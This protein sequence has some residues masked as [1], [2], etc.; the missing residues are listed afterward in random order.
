LAVV[1]G[2][3]V[4]ILPD[5]EAC[6]D[7]AARLIAG[8][9]REAAH[10]R[11]VAHWATTGGSTPAP[12]YRELARP[13]L[14]DEVPWEAVELWWGDDRY[15]P[16]DHPL[17]NVN[18]AT[19]GLIEMAATSGQSG[20]GQSGTDVLAG[21]TAGAPIPPGNVHPIPMTAAIAEGGGPELAADRYAA[22]LIAAGPEFEDGVPKFDLL[23]AGV[24]PDGHVLSVF[25]G[26]P[27]F[28]RPEPV[29]GVP[30][31]S[32]VEPHVARVTLNPRVIAVARRV[33][34]VTHGT[35]K[36]EMI[37]NVLGTEIDVRRWPA[38]LARREEATWILDEAAAAALR[39]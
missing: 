25:P 31:P 19:A 30:A 38:Q 21:R 22:E 7:A 36:A 6:A 37:G 1:T 26:S 11:G 17:S 15:V 10:G 9:L 39:R 28:D 20:T 5:P 13:P 2:E 35:E 12:V 34:V 4:Q 14:R 24:G 27:T 23:F 16:I 18:V 29:L 33:L 8:V 32:H 3:Q